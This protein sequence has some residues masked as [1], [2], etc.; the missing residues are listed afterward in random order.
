[1]DFSRI[2]RK[3]ALAGGILRTDSHADM[4]NGTVVFVNKVVNVYSGYK[5]AGG[6]QGLLWVCF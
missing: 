3:E 1:M 5:H 4:K 6:V 2:K